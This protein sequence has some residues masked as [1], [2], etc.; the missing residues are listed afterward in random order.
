M[1]R[2]ITLGQ[3]YRT[4]SVIH[5]LDPRVKIVA[6]FSFIISLFIAKIIRTVDTLPAGEHTSVIIGHS[7]YQTRIV[8][9]LFHAM[10]DSL[11]I[12]GRFLQPTVS[13][14]SIYTS[15]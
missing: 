1:L 11:V 10:G 5:R 2:E 3:Y 6:T 12:G 15:H 7:H 9:F 4:E 13:V 8:E 14:I